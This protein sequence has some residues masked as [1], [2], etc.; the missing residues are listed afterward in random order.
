MQFPGQE[1]KR[2]EKRESKIRLTQS[3]RRSNGD[4]LDAPKKFFC[5]QLNISKDGA[6]ETRPESFARMYRNGGRS[7]V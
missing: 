7:S 1:R 5:G 6:K 3:W 2:R 4:V